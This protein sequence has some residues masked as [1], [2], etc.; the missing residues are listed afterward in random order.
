MRLRLNNFA[1]LPRCSRWRPACCG[2]FTLI[3]MLVVLVII[4]I[5]AALALPHIRGNTE[6]TAINAACYQLVEDLSF[7]RQKAISQRSTVAVVFVSSN[8]L[9]NA[10]GAPLYNA[11]EIARH[12]EL[13]GGVF[14]H[15]AFYSFRRAGEQ[16][17]NGTKGYITE[18]K[19]LPEKTF[20]DPDMFSPGS[21][22]WE[23]P[24]GTGRRVEKF[25]FP[26]TRENINGSTSLPYLAFDYEGRCVKLTDSLTGTTE[27]DGETN[28]IRIARGS[29]LF[30]RETDGRVLSGNYEVQQIPPYN[31]T[32]N[33]IRVDF[34]TGRAKRL[35]LELK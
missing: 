18:W 16:P 26:L 20:I 35:E 30:T 11:K 13:Q 25:A 5:I 7:A 28:D 23:D 24:S 2:A 31:A 12:K 6:S 29:I 8:I 10:L 14:T 15:Y 9:G 27:L 17:G 22:F 32:N 19:S 21:I 4:G 34:L 3:E 1:S 33:I